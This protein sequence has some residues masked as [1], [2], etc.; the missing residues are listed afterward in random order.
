MLI[1]LCHVNALL[2]LAGGVAMYRRVSADTAPFGT[3]GALPLWILF[4][5]VYLA[6]MV[7]ATA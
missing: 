4:A 5:P 2:V 1:P 6:H 3:M 7:A